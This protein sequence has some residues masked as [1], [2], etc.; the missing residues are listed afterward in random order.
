MKV[1]ILD[2]SKPE[3]VIHELFDADENVR[4]QFKQHFSSQIINFSEAI[5]PAFSRFPNFSED[6]KHCLQTALVCGF[7]HGV[8]DDLVTSVKLLLTGK[9]TASGNLFRQAI[10][11]ICMAV[12]CS[13]QSTLS[14]GDK[15]CIYWDLVK[16]QAKE[17]E[18]C[19]LY[20]SDAADE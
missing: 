16:L 7:V 12:M 19:L 4:E 17:V 13:H 10:E 3:V 6:G 20:T 1:P 8:L 9:L 5:S 15:E 2:L 14:I 18:G 11:G